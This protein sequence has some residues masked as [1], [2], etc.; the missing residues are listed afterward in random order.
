[1]RTR[2]RA[3]VRALRRVAL[4]GLAVCGLTGAAITGLVAAPQPFFPHHL[5]QRGFE[6]WSDMP[7]DPA[8]GRRL[9]A[10]VEDRL[11]RSDLGPAAGA[12][13]IFVANTAWRERLFFLWAYGAAGVNVLPATRHA[14]LRRADIAADR[15]FGHS[16]KAADP[17]RTLAY[18][19]AHELAHG[20]TW[21][22]TGL[23]AFFTMPR[24]LREGVADYVA[25]G[26]G[27]AMRIA[28]EL[29]ADDARLWP[30][31]SGQY[32][33]FHLIVACAREAGG[34]TTDQLLGLRIDEDEA[35]ARWL[36]PGSSRARACRAPAAEADGRT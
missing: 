34:L 15:L 30:E 11:A 10:D 36:A 16:G 27:Q 20:L 6:L 31:R 7:F 28:G 3:I 18:Y 4:L 13:R 33:R 32:L 21:E 19:A 9:L 35:A 8:D 12:R 26:R 22:R 25:L 14:F 17:P 5:Q 2:L 24:W 1:M 29:A 23:L